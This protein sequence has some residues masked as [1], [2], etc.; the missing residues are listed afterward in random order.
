MFA[1]SLSG[2]D[3]CNRI[4]LTSYLRPKDRKPVLGIFGEHMMSRAG[5]IFSLRSPMQTGLVLAATIALGLQTSV[6][7]ARAADDVDALREQ[8]RILQ[9]ENSSLKLKLE[10]QSEAIKTL[11][12]RLDALEQEAPETALTEEA[13]PAEET[14]LAAEKLDIEIMNKGCWRDDGTEQRC[15]DPAD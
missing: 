14:A 4:S 10:S 13:A 1:R 8:F 6:L 5:P 11:M 9:D 7:P 15:I 3:A 12:E 2:I